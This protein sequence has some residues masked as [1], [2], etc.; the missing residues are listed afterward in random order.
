MLG[1]ETWYNCK[2][3]AVSGFRVRW[4]G[5]EKPE[6]SAQFYGSA[7]IDRRLEVCLSVDPVS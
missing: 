2:S 7:I 4:S 5:T 1:G 3:E 6:L